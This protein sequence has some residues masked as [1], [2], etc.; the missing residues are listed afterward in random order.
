MICVDISVHIRQL[1]KKKGR[2]AD[3]CWRWLPIALISEHA[4]FNCQPTAGAPRLLAT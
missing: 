3:D 2:G 4:S 1:A